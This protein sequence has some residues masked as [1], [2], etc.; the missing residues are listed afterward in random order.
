MLNIVL[1]PTTVKFC[2]SRNF[3]ENFIFENS[4]KK[5]ICD[6]KYSRLVHCFSISVNDSVISQFHEDFIFTKFRISEIRKNET[7]AKF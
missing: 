2:K 1:L 4:V 7:L 3:R 6:A 5:H